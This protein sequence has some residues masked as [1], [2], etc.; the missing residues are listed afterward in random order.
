MSW[1]EGDM[2]EVELGDDNGNVH[3][4]GTIYVWCRVV[5]GGRVQMLQW[6][7]DEPVPPADTR[8]TAEW[9]QSMLH[10][11]RF[12]ERFDRPAEKGMSDG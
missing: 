6:W 1:A 5:E 11:P 12:P 8:I 3:N 2:V 10:Y 9:R 4:P 7:S